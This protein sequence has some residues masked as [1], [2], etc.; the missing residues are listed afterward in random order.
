MVSALL[1]LAGLFLSLYLTLW[2]YGFMGALQCGTGGCEVVQ[3]SRWATVAGLPVAA[4]GVGGYLV[5][6]VIAM[7]GVQE[8]W[9][10][11]REPTV[12]LVALSGIGVVFTAYLT[13]LEA[14]VI[15]AWC[16][17]CLGSAAIIVLIFA[18]NLAGLRRARA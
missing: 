5:L 12:W 18:V 14:F 17:W 6:L 11:R 16:R 3:T 4:V 7:V 9:A 15:D 10:V 2:H 13:Y 1:A 8:R